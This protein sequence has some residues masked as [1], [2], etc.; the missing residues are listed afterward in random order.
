[1]SGLAQAGSR[2]C[3]AALERAGFQVVR[4]KG[5]HIVMHRDVPFAQ[6]VVPG[7]KVIGKGLLRSI[8]NQTG[9][10]PDAFLKLL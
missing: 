3:V 6:T 7:R 5:S 8:L 4:Q 2:E 10:S 9:L 1:M